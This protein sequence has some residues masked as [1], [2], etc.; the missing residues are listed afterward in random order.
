MAER[1]LPTVMQGDRVCGEGVERA[2]GLAQ[3]A[4]FV[5]ARPEMS[6]DVDSPSTGNAE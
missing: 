6:G 1:A 2:A 5:L 3:L 4:Q